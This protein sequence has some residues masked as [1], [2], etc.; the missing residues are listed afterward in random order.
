[1]KH[2]LTSV[3]LAAAFAIA[4]PVSA[5]QASP[6]PTPATA[7]SASAP[8]PSMADTSPATAPHRRH[9]RASYATH[10]K[11]A[12]RRGGGSESTGDIANQLNQQE[13]A[14]AQ[15]GNFTNPPVG[16]SAAAPPG[17]APASSAR[18]VGP[19]AAGSGYI[20]PQPG[21]GAAAPKASPKT[22][23]PGQGGAR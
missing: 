4:G 15:A 18:M 14:R 9:A 23:G 8:P 12:P 10:G 1:M 2:L 6:S 7:P 3:A 20:Q 19:K 11:M 22:I 13:L 16:P 21:A 17:P 5:Q